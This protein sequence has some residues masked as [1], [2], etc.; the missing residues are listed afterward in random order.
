[1]DIFSLKS[2]FQ[3]LANMFLALVNDELAMARAIKYEK[4]SVFHS[5]QIEMFNMA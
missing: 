2:V 3:N 1:M 5:N 4:Y